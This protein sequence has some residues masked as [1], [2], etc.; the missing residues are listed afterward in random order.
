MTGAHASSRSR[1]LLGL[2]A[3]SLASSK[4]A[5]SPSRI[6]KIWVGIGQHGSVRL[7]RLPSRIYENAELARIERLDHE[8][9]SV[10][11]CDP[12][13][14]AKYA[15]HGFWIRFNVTKVGALSLPTSTPPRIL[16]AGCSPGCLLAATCTSLR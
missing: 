5:G 7:C 12:T 9:A 4:S 3:Q 1:S 15:D 10:I 2:I 8:M 6:A 14:A 16:D 13:Y 11:E